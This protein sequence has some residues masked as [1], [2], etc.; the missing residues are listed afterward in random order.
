MN[1]VLPLLVVA[2]VVAL[3]ASCIQLAARLSRTPPLSWFGSLACALTVLAVAVVA[4][5]LP[6]PVGMPWLGV[7]IGIVIAVTASGWVL[8]RLGA[9]A[10]GA[11]LGAG[12]GTGVMALGTV[13][14]GALVGVL[15]YLLH[16]MHPLSY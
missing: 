7:V 15:L 16:R 1:L 14:F 3:F 11:V 12:R 13:L 4:A 6:K 5:M 9:A 2:V 8:G 10:A